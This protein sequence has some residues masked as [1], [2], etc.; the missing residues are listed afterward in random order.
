M[1]KETVGTNDV[2]ATN[3]ALHAMTK[4]RFV[5]EVTDGLLP[6]QLIS[7]QIATMNKK[8]N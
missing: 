1:S 6:P 4:T 3:Y 7:R 5:K 8:A 2:K